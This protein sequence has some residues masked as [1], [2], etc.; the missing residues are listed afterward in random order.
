[1]LTNIEHTYAIAFIRHCLYTITTLNQTPHNVLFL[2][3]AVCYY[4]ILL[5]HVNIQSY[6]P[7][8][9][10][11]TIIPTELYKSFCCR[12]IKQ[13]VWSNTPA[14]CTLFSD[15]DLYLNVYCS[16]CSFCPGSIWHIEQ[17]IAKPKHTFCIYL[18]NLIIYSLL[19]CSTVF[20]YGILLNISY[21][22]CD[23]VRL[24]LNIVNKN[25]ILI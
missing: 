6:S 3:L 7:T 11:A 15:C 4:L 22:T 9:I 19:F 20:V 5:Y 1:M 10:T 13:Y 12:A 14:L 17:C 24:Y 21:V 23:S 25:A 18:W 8:T 2:I 16:L